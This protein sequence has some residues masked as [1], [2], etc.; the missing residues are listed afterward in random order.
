MILKRF[1]LKKIYD[2]LPNAEKT[3]WAL[4]S[5]YSG[6]QGLYRYLR[7]NGEEVAYNRIIQGLKVTVGPSRFIALT[8]EFTQQAAQDTIRIDNVAVQEFTNSLL[9]LKENI[10]RIIPYVEDIEE[11]QSVEDLLDQFKGMVKNQ[12][13][14][15]ELINEL[16]NTEVKMS[17]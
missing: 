13:E 3:Q 5:G 12:R 15:L 17:K 6:Y 14:R 9:A 1:Q 10:V 11:L 4:N 2:Q 16:K 8:N 7:Q